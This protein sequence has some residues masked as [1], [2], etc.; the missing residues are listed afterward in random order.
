[1]LPVRIR[2]FRLAAVNVIDALNAAKQMTKHGLGNVNS[3]TGSGHDLDRVLI[4][5]RSVTVT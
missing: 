1:V 5:S 4:K 3:D 2:L